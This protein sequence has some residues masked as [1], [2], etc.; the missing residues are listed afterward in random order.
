MSNSQRIYERACKVMPGGNTRDT[1]FFQPYPIY[2]A[3]GKGC[4]VKDVEGVTRIDFVNN[5]SA[6]IHGHRNP[7]IDEAVRRQ[8]DRLPAVGMP[9]EE[10]VLLAELLC[11]EIPS[12]ERIRFTNSGTEAIMMA[13]KVA[14]LYTGKSKIAKAEGAYH[15][16]YDW[17]EVSVAPSLYDAGPASSPISVPR[18]GAITSNVLNDV[19]VLN[20]N[21]IEGTRA[22]IEKNADQLAAVLIDPLVSRM[23]YAAATMDYLEMLRE[24]TERCGVLLVFDEVYTL[25]LARGGVQ[26]KRGITPDLTAMGKII[27][28]CFP[29]GGVGGRADIMV[30]FDP[31]HGR[32]R[33]PHGGTYNA[34]PITMVA[35]YA[36]MTQLTDAAYA[37][38]DRLG[39]RA[40]QGLAEVLAI[41]GADAQVTGEGSVLAIVPARKPFKNWREYAACEA[42]HANMAAFHRHMLDSG[43]LM[44]PHGTFVLS[45]PMTDTEIDAMVSA[46]REGVRLL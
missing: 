1:V 32:P 10:E 35:G 25:R 39:E 20:Y 9:T 17:I 4:Y 41:A 42:R 46:T 36:S 18:S 43:I 15:G 16:S 8:L 37:H 34:N 28:G 19:I 29:V 11:G 5:Y 44:A 13:L 24:V 14:K 40:R 21:D 26:K 23:G 27:G 30:A 2:A 33:L 6:L 31:S 12:V 3:S 7:Q 45:T 38:L 22:L